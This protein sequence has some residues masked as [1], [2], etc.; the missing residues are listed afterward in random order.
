[1]TGV[2]HNGQTLTLSL[3][4]HSATHSP[5]HCGHQLYLDGDACSFGFIVRLLPPRPSWVR[6]WSSY[7]RIVRCARRR[8]CR[9]AVTIIAA[10]GSPRVTQGC[11]LSRHRSSE[12][13]AKHPRL[14]RRL[15][16][17]RAPR[18]LVANPRHPLAPQ[19]VASGLVTRYVAADRIGTINPAGTS[20]TSNSASPPCPYET[21]GVRTAGCE[22]TPHCRSPAVRSRGTRTGAAPSWERTQRSRGPAASLP[23]AEESAIQVFGAG[24]STVAFERR[25]KARGRVLW[26]PAQVT[27]RCVCW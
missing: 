22:Q 7:R 6:C 3:V 12:L 5:W 9:N 15:V 21:V 16:P 24:A 4:I 8:T 27:D 19:L 2:S 11:R 10:V 14:R 25:A 20:T 23:Q 26:R 13:T 1:M 17:E 18:G